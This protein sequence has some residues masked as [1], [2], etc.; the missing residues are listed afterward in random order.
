MREREVGYG[1]WV[2]DESYHRNGIAEY[3]S[4]AGY[5]EEQGKAMA[6]ALFAEL[7]EAVN[8]A[9][10]GDAMW[11]PRLSAVLWHGDEMPPD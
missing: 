11:L 10:P 5:T 9:L 8:A 4:N 2:A 3:L 1:S 6:D 7:R